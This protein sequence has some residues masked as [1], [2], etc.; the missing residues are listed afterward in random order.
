MRVAPLGAYFA[1][2]ETQLIEQARRSAVVTHANPDGQAGAIAVAAAAGWAARG[3]RDPQEL[4]RAALAATPQGPT[5]ALVEKVCGL[6][7]ESEPLS[8]ALEVGAGWNVLCADTVPFC[9][10]AFARHLNSFEEAL[11]TTASVPGD[12]DTN[13]AIVGGLMAALTG[14]EVI[15]EDWRAAREPLRHDVDLSPS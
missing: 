2:D 7:P 6:A 10:W 15:P 11:W 5:R 4:F 9:L 1:D 14:V 12:R 3:A 8:V 13:G